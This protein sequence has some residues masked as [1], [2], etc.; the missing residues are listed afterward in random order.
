MSSPV[1]GKVTARHLSRKAYLYVRQST[2]RQVFENTESTKRQYDL[3]QTAT[4]LG[5]APDDV[6]VIDTDLGKSGAS[7][8]RE[9]FQTLVAQVGLGR[10]GVVLSLEV[11]RLARNSTEW[12]K[13]L[14]ICALTDTLIVDEAGVYDP[15]QFNDRLLL[16]LKGTMSEAELHVMRARLRGGL[17]NKARRGELECALPVGLVHDS[18]GR[19]VLDP[20]KQVQASIRLL[21]ETFSRTGTAYATATYFQQRE[22]GFPARIHGGARHGELEWRPLQPQRVVSVLHNPRYA[23]AFV[24]G[25]SQTRRLAQGGYSSHQLPAEQWLA[26][27]LDAHPG[28]ITWEQHQGHLAQLARTAHAF[29]QDARHGPAREGCALLQGVLLC[30]VCGARMSVRYHRRRGDSLAPYYVCARAGER[31]PTQVCTSI[32]GAG[33]DAAVSDLLVS[34]LTPAAVEIA[35]EVEREIR[36]RVEELDRLRMQQVQRAQYAADMARRRFMQVDPDNRL[37]ASSL[38]EDWNTALRALDEARCALERQRAQDVRVRDPAERD[39]LLALTERFSEVWYATTTPH[40]ERKRMLRL[41]IEDVTVHKGE[42]VTLHV[43]FRGG[44]TTT[45]SIPRA[46]PNWQLRK[47]DSQIV[48]DVNTMLDSM[49]YTQIAEELNS[50]GL[51]SGGGAPFDAL[52]VRTI[53]AAYHLEP[54]KLRLRRMGRIGARQLAR[55]LGVDIGTIYNWL[56][57]GR[58]QG[59]RCND[60]REYMFHPD[61][62]PAEP[63]QGARAPGTRRRVS[64]QPRDRNEEVQYE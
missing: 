29:G 36:V 62:V 3:R 30:G 47:T 56:A 58:I 10:A 5:W 32:P 9:G 35:L 63:A 54:L 17:L 18:Q 15:S 49:T 8:D 60:K 20:D 42:D 39:R 37:V 43:R 4:A 64:G 46:R 14:E 22:L 57:Q 13:L 51:R 24:Y 28:Y 1:S 33:L 11:S 50:R 26:L 59:T 38:E 41:M 31:L 53:V 48:A 2:V 7:A 16:G 12:H 19:V 25:R 52:G 44:R 27:V 61:T 40:R 34:T 6:I 21:F 45:L 23:G 55:K